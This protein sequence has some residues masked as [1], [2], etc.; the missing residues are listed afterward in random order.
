MHSVIL[1]EFGILLHLAHHDDNGGDAS[2]DAIVGGAPII[3]P[4][5]NEMRYALV[6]ELGVDLDLCH[7]DR[8]WA[9]KMAGQ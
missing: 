6:K 5:T 9:W 4:G 7:L 3:L 1:V 8:D 2:E